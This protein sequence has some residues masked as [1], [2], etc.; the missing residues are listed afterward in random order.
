[1]K[2]EKNNFYQLN[3]LDRIE[4]RQRYKEIQEFYRSD[5]FIT[6]TNTA[7]F[8]VAFLF[9]F[10]NGWK[11]N[12]EVYYKLINLMGNLIGISIAL[13]IASLIETLI[14]MNIRNKEIRKLEEEY[15]KWGLNEKRKR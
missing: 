13:L 1:M 8:W 11:D 7:I 3:Q 10:S 12:P 9:L 15:F 4:F 2:I 6:L 14:F 5:I